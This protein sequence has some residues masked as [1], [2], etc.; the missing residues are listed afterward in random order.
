[1]ATSPAEHWQRW[2]CPIMPKHDFHTAMSPITHLLESFPMTETH[3]LSHPCTCGQGRNNKILKR[4]N[5]LIEKHK[6]NNGPQMFIGKFG[7]NASSTSGIQHEHATQNSQAM[8]IIDFSFVSN[9]FFR[10]KSG[11]V[12]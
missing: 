9:P 6:S 7:T 1:M 10:G 8:N 4:V 2:I 11:F 12:D 3:W 5:I